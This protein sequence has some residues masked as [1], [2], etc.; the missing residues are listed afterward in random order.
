VRAR[1]PGGEAAKWTGYLPLFVPSE[2]NAVV[3]GV[4]VHVEFRPRRKPDRA[5]DL[6]AGATVGDLLRAVGEPADHTLAVRGDTPVSEGEAL[7]NGESI[8][9]L[10]AFSGG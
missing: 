3:T 2:G 5:V 4:R 9:L 10:S 1:R 7:R 6:A 8:L